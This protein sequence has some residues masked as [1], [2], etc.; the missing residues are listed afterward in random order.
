MPIG[1]TDL[2]IY[3]FLYKTAGARKNKYAVTAFPN[4]GEILVL[5]TFA[6]SYEEAFQIA[7]S[8]Y[9]A[10]TYPK[11]NVSH[12]AVHG[13]CQSSTC[14]CGGEI[15]IKKFPLDWATTR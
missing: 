15:R 2:S 11:V 7:K 6:S 12:F 10:S 14:H 8:A 4:R 13:I 9:E 3:G 5:F 1:E